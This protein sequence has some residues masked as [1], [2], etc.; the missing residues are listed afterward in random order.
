MQ[1]TPVY[2]PDPL[3]VLEGPGAGILEPV[4]R[5]RRRLVAELGRLDEAQWSHATRCDGW[6]VRD[7]IVHLDSTNTFWSFSIGAG[8]AGTPTTFLATFDPVAS[9]AA[10]VAADDEPP[11]AVLERFADSTEALA[12]QME[13]LDEGQWQALAEAPP[14]H[15]TVSALAHHALWDSWVHERDILEPLG[16]DQVIQDDEVTAS[17]TYAAALSPAFSVAMGHGRTGVLGVSTADPAVELTVEIGDDVRVRTGPASGA[18]LVL[19]GDSVELL[20]ALSVRRPLSGAVPDGSEWM[21]QGL[22]EVFDVATG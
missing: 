13:S 20:E 3:I 22:L 16:I 1:L 11:A 10:L 6:D 14:G 19:E 12:A 7:V 18:D 2:G 8:V 21:V 17:L 15:V 5:Q 4:V 9:P